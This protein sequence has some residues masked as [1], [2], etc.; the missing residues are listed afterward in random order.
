MLAGDDARAARRERHKATANQDRFKQLAQRYWKHAVF[1]TALALLVSAIA[2]TQ[3]TG[4]GQKDCPGHWHASFQVYVDDEIVNMA[5]TSAQNPDAPGF[6]MHGN[7]NLM[8]THP[9]APRCI[10]LDDALASLNIDASSRGID[11]GPL[12]GAD[13]SSTQ[14][15]HTTGEDKELAIYHQPWQG[16]WRQ[17]STSFLKEQIGNGDRLLITY[18][19]LDDETIARQQA[20]VPEI[21]DNDRPQ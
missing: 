2:V 11:I 15:D 12:P 18:G 21:P 13:R 9:A 5:P 16:E 1:F 7:D 10:P 8:H 17:V 20:A 3:T 19:A 6:H 14:G 4:I